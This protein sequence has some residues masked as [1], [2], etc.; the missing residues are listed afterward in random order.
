LEDEDEMLARDAYDE[1]AKAP[2]DTVK[3]LEPKMD[4][5]RLISF[6]NNPEVP[7]NRRRLYFTMLGVCGTDADAKM[8]EEFMRSGDRKKKAGLD[9]LIA[10]YLILTG[11]KG[12]DKVEEQ[13]LQNKD[14]E[15]ADTYAAIMAIRFHGS[16]VDVIPRTRLTK[17]LHHMLERPE[18]ADLVIPDLARWEDWT[19]MNRLVDLFTNADENSSWVRVPVVNYLRAC[20]LP[21]A[22]EKIEVLRTIDAEAVKRAMTFFPMSAE[23]D[24]DSDAESKTTSVDESSNDLGAT[25]EQDAAAVVGTTRESNDTSSVKARLIAEATQLAEAKK[26]TTA[27]ARV[28]ESNSEISIVPPGTLNE[29]ESEAANGPNLF[30]LLG[31]TMLCAAVC[32]L[33]MR[34]A[35]GVNN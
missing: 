2:Y 28:K 31:V 29:V 35:I 21:I 27:M 12:L 8:L 24:N 33:A 20:P 9:S 1:F 13:F 26:P 25:A 19:V 32:L 10:C 3:A 17:S 18:L 7:S 16:E 5:D 11:D 23:S 15:Y 22:E 34:T 14:A 6:V 30:K 4:H